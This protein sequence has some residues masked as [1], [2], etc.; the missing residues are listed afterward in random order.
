M[1]ST[2][3]TMSE[4]TTSPVIV[5]ASVV[6]DAIADPGP[7]GK[8]ARAALAAVPADEPLRA[9]GHLAF[10]ILSGMWAAAKRPEHPLTPESVPRALDDAAALGIAIEATPWSDVRRAWELSLGSLR[11]A[12]AVYA[13]AAERTGEALLTADTRIESSGAR[14]TCEVLTVRSPD[15]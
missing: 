4:R 1:P 15:D 3:L 10:E 9:P 8:A 6:I 5:D 13:A 11:Y 7:R 2:P 12:D 14:T